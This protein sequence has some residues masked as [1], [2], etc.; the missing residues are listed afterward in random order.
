MFFI[1]YNNFNSELNVLMN[2][3][4]YEFPHFSTSMEIHKRFFISK[5]KFMTLFT[6]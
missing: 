1:L 5:Y 6:N 4:F 3:D 2:R